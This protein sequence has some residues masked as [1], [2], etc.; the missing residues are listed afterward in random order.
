M[1]HKEQDLQIRCVHWFRITYPAFACL[2]FHPKN[3]EAG[4]RAR[5]AIAKAEG[6]QAGVADLILQ[7]PAWTGKLHDCG[8]DKAGNRLLTTSTYSALAIELKTKTG[9]QS[10][11]QKQWQR[12]FEAV[13]GRYVVVRTFEEFQASVRAHMCAVFQDTYDKAEAVYKKIEEERLA[14]AKR[15]L[16]KLIKK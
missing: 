10:E 9:R 16:Q 14:E 13:G 5:A 4:G 6:V 15:E 3:E 7:V 2:M 11:K 8:A 1:R 12:Y